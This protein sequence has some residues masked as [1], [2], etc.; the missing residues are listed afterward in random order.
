MISILIPFKNTA[1]FFREC[2]D[3]ILAQSHSAFEIIAVDD[4]SDDDSLE[5][6]KSYS[7]KRIQVFKN[8]GIGILPALQTAQKHA[9]GK[10]ITRMDADDVM[11]KDKLFVLLSALKQKGQGYVATGMVQYFGKEKVSEGYKKYENWIN[12]VCAKNSFYEEIYRECVVASPN[13]MMHK[14]DFD[15][16][17]GFKE[18]QYPEDYDM[19]FK[20]KKAG[21]Q[22]HGI[23]RITHLWR[24]HK[25]RT[26]RTNIHYQQASFFKLKT[27]Y[28]LRENKNKNIVLL[29]AKKKGRIIAKILTS[30][31]IKFRWFE[32][33][34]KLID[35]KVMGVQIE[36]Y[37]TFIS[38]NKNTACIISVYPDIHHKEKLEKTLLKKGF[39]IGKTAHYF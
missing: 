16:I 26:S 2:I 17:S 15:L 5:I 33:D 14:E 4:H 18:I 32:Q 11:P 31:N 39:F 30:Q 25:N 10:F 27:S 20:W 1:P 23:K 19:V 34:E 3:S 8:E 21:L 7:D 29:G 9:T 38:K 13:W 28:F 24:E 12:K 36:S 35:T 37:K 6:I 22:I